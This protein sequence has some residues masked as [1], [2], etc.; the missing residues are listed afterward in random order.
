MTGQKRPTLTGI[1]EELVSSN[2]KRS[3]KETSF[4]LFLYLLSI[5]VMVPTYPQ[6]ILMRTSSVAEASLLNGWLFFGKCIVEFTCMPVMGS[7]SDHAGRKIVFFVAGFIAV[8]EYICLALFPSKLVICST[9][10]LGGLTNGV[11]T[12][13]FAAIADVSKSISGPAVSKNF[14]LIGAAFGV[15][16]IIGPL[17]GGIL[18]QID[19]RI[20]CCIA[21]ALNTL[22]L[23]YISIAFQETLHHDDRID[24]DLQNASPLPALAIFRDRR[25][26]P[27]LLLPL[28][29][30]HLGQGVTMT[31]ILWLKYKFDWGMEDVGKFMSFCGL[32]VSFFQG[33]VIRRV[34]PK[35]VTEEHAAVA[36][37][38]CRALAYV[39]YAFCTVPW[40]MFLLVAVDAMSS[41]ADPCLQGIMVRFVSSQE[42][43][44][45][46]GASASVR[47]GAQALGSA[48]FSYAM[49]YFI[50]TSV[51]STSDSIGGDDTSTYGGS[52]P[53]GHWLIG[54]CITFF[55]ACSAQAGFH[56]WAI[57]A[58][59]DTTHEGEHGGG[60]HSHRN[61][62]C[63]DGIALGGKG[64]AHVAAERDILLKKKARFAQNGA[65]GSNGEVHPR[66]REASIDKE[67]NENV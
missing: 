26:L 65:Y 32:S 7:Y 11:L 59:D 37:Y 43:G 17:T 36:G 67:M 24:F 8:C 1:E 54:A 2:M 19:T 64:A 55:A 57:C 21:V 13:S 25:G 41:M 18:G 50:G 6:L 23:L 9:R 27:E 4:I 38:L 45:L 15:A 46:Q 22:L 61:V 39:G 51:E 52:L 66:R 31:W 10:I 40:V 53:G 20:P 47:T 5:G 3:L 58:D 35:L 62:V 16:F 28:F 30:T 12:M 29:L 48:L 60:G 33:F 14:G 44:T 63:D 42:L 56:H 49:A 34:V